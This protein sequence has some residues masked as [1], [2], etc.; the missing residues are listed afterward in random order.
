MV[1][2]LGTRRKLRLRTAV[3]DRRLRT[4]PLGRAHGVHGHVAAA[5][6]HNALPDV[7]RRIVTRVV[8]VHQIGARK[9]FVGRDHPVQ[10]LAPD[11]HKTRQTGTRT[12]EHGVESLLAEQRI[13]RHRAP[14]DHVGLDLDAQPPHGLDLALDDLLLGQSELRN[15]VD[16][17]PAHLVQCLENLHFVTHLGQVARTGQTRRPA[18]HDSHPTAVARRQ[19]R[20]ALRRMADVPVAHEPFELAHGHRLALDAEHAGPFALRLLRADAAADRRQRTVAGDHVGS[21]RHIAFAQAG[22]EIGNLHPDRTGRHA[23]GIAAM[24]ATRR[25]G[26]CLFEIIPVA[27]LFEIGRT[28]RR[29]LFAHRHARYFVRHDLLR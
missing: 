4:E 22:D 13:D 7:D 17:H 14:D 3:D 28:E 15:A 16:Q 25:F 8:G 9:E 2:L 12:D 24:Q 23:A 5:D 29:I 19:R 20:G 26:P 21:P 11:P 1:H 27:D 6:H 18:P 10:V